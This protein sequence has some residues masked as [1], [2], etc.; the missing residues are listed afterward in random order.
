MNLITRL[1]MLRML[2]RNDEGQDLLEYALLVALIALVAVGA[3][4]TTG[5]RRQHDLRQHQHRALGRGRP[6]DRVL[7]GWG[8]ARVS[9]PSSSLLSFLTLG[10]HV[11]NRAG[12]WSIAT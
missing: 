6:V 7:K 3:I 9:G 8:R 4:T 12:K 5:D 11:R 1:R 10:F 2:R